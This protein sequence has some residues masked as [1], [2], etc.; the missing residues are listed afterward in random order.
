MITCKMENQI[1]EHRIFVNEL[2]SLCR[3][4]AEVI[5]FFVGRRDRPGRA[6]TATAAECPRIPLLVNSVNSALHN[7]S[8]RAA[9]RLDSLGSKRLQLLLSR[10]LR[11]LPA[12][13]SA[14]T[15]I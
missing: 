10:L 3:D 13:R 8:R 1:D 9:S 15:V 7:K 6:V 12:V 2:V 4:W 14:V 11:I 5:E